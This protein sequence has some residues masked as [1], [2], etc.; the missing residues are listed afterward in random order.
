MDRA[1]K[2]RQKKRKE[3]AY[4]TGERGVNRVRAFEQGG[5]LF[6]EY[7][8]SEAGS[9]V[10]R[11]K[12]LAIRGDRSVAKSKADELAVAFRREERNDTLHVTCA[13]LFDIYEGEVSVGKGRFTRLHDKSALEMFRRSFGAARDVRT[14]NRRDWD[15]FIR[16]RQDGTLQP[17]KNYRKGGVRNRTITYDLKLVVAVFNWAVLSGLLDKNPFKGLPFPVELNPV[18]KMF[19]EEQ[20]ADLIEQARAI[21]PQYELLL[22]VCYYTGHRIGS[23]RHLRWSN[24]DFETNGITWVAEHDKMGRGHETPLKAELKEMLQ[25]AHQQQAAAGDAWVFPS[26][27]APDRPVSAN[28]ARDWMERGLRKIGVGVG[29]RYGYHSVRREFATNLDRDG[30]SLAQICALGGW[31]DPTTVMKCYM[32]P[33][34]AAMR[35]ALE[36]RPSLR[37]LGKG[38]RAAQPTPRI[39]TYD[40]PRKNPTT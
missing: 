22:S 33:N 3:W 12:R 37:S 24:I 9:P 8:V 36:N 40:G 5:K 26:P 25:Q 16:Q 11:R 1:R 6:V 38:P 32:R 19:T 31:Q 10:P 2:S 29:Q 21:N 34:Q 4:S 30:V 35:A 23:V 28:L 20:Y 15:R 13:R 7:Y 17:R 27:E 39:D 14:L 18:R